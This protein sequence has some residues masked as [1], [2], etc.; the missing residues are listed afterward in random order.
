MLCMPC[1]PPPPPP[2]C[3]LPRASRLPQTPKR[4]ILSTAPPIPLSSGR[5][6]CNASCQPY[7]HKAMSVYSASCHPSTHRGNVPEWSF[8]PP[9]AITRTR[10]HIMLSSVFG[11]LDVIQVT[12][13]HP[14]TVEHFMQHPEWSCHTFLPRY[15]PTPLFLRSS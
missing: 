7:N 9:P 6:C 3:P 8:M 11:S 15:V 10:H 5:C 12:H 13:N 1:P 2:S 4:C 14:C